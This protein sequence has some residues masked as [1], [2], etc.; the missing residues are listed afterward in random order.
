MLRLGALYRYYPCPLVSVRDRESVYAEIG[1][2]IL[3][4]LADF[5]T[6]A[7][8]IETIRG[9]HIHMEDRKTSVLIPKNR[10]DQVIKVLNNSSEHI[11]AFGADFSKKA[12]GH[13][14]CIQKIDT[15]DSESMSYTTQAINIQGQERNVTG[16]S[17]FIL[18]GALKTNSG[19]TG[20]CS[21]VEDGL[22]VQILPT[23]MSSIRDS[24][25]NMKNI[26]I[27]CGHANADEKQTEIVSIEWTEN[28]VNFNTGWVFLLFY[29]RTKFKFQI[30][31][32]VI[33]PIDRLSLHGIPSIRVHRG[34]DYSN[35]NH[36]IRWTEVFIIKSDE[37]GT[38]DRSGARSI[39]EDQM[40]ISKIAEQ[41]AK[42]TCLALVSFLDL[43]VSNEMTRIGLRVTLEENVWILFRFF[44]FVLKY[45][46]F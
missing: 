5:R 31:F 13:L 42:S 23:K 17:F 19:F 46:Y 28:D 10:Y 40:D 7:Y 9:M 16:A 20:K 39:N 11:I 25:R 34:L 2:T 45:W 35:K 38:A 37:E 6:Y 8:T 26:E 43:L 32:R 24:L 33:S 4:F 12:D 44:E 27:I 22:M 3:N 15:G 1:Q 36:M 41:I 21:I 30:F 18:N 14:V 29:L